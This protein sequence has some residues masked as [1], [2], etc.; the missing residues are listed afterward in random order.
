[1]PGD[2]RQLLKTRF[3]ITGVNFTSTDIIAMLE[4]CSYETQ[5]LGYSAFCGLFSEE[6]FLNYEYYFDLVSFLGSVISHS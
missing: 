3:Q 6:D 1:M 4:L 5:A 2:T